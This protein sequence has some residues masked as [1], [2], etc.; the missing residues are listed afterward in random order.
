V[1]TTV[2]E[3]VG[4][5]RFFSSNGVYSRPIAVDSPFRKRSVGR[6]KDY[7][8]GPSRVGPPRVFEA[9]D[10]SGRWRTLPVWRALPRKIR[11]AARSNLAVNLAVKLRRSLRTG[12]NPNTWP[13]SSGDRAAVS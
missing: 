7:R 9:V 2:S 4:R 8:A 3:T 10:G 12:P 5:Q 1:L 6:S 13:R 11:I